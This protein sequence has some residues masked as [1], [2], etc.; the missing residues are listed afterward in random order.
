MDILLSLEYTTETFGS[1]RT[2]L[3][4][5]TVKRG[6]TYITIKGPLFELKYN[7]SHLTYK[8]VTENGRN[9]LL[10]VPHR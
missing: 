4:L 10:V 9:Y 7:S 5:V 6:H 1:Y 2:A 8:T 3:G